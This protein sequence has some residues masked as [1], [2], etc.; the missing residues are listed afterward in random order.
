MKIKVRQTAHCV[1]IT[2]LG[3]AYVPHFFLLKKEVEFLATKKESHCFIDCDNLLHVKTG[4]II[5][6]DA[7]SQRSS[8][9]GMVGYVKISIDS[10][11]FFETV[12]KLL[13]KG[14]I[15]EDESITLESSRFEF[16]CERVPTMT[17]AQIIK[18][19]R[20]HAKKTLVQA[21]QVASHTQLIGLREHLSRLLLQSKAIYDDSGVA[22]FYFCQADGEPGY[23]GGIIYNKNSGYSV[24]T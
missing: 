7:A 12:Q 21:V 23:N 16:K 17:F 20:F 4:E 14:I 15:P 24:H 2:V 3:N 13:V 18:S 9:C 6:V 5:F 19:Y 8:E 11:K 10:F 1:V 22:S